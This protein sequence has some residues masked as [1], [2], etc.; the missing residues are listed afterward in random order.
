MIMLLAKLEFVTQ[1]T[2]P[3]E[4]VLL[5]VG[6]LLTLGLLIGFIVLLVLQREKK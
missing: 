6:A 4:F 1:E 3:Y 5:S 2:R